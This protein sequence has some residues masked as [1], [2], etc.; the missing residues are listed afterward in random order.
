VSNPSNELHRWARLRPEESVAY[1]ILFQ[2]VWFRV[3]ERHE[4][5]VPAMAGYMWLDLAG[6]EQ[7]VC[8]GHFEI[9]DRARHRILI[10]DD[11]PAIRRTLQIALSGVGHEVF[12]AGD[13][14]EGTRM[15]HETGP[16]L[17]IADIHMPR[18]SGLLLMEDL[19]ARS[20]S[21][22]VIAM[23][24]GGPASD[25]HL[26]GLAQLLGAIRTVPKPFSLPDMLA[27]VDEELRERRR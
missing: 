23:T 25:F 27:V 9:V 19:R 26:L 18:K 14:E 7:R 8:A 12:E 17:V 5:D 16:D 20:A 6:G 1:P 10:V 2:D 11:D 22:R 13:G 4:P 21:T 3:V 24:D 15:W